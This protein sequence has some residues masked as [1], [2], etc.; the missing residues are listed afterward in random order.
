MSGK[1]KAESGILLDSDQG[2]PC[3]EELSSVA[4]KL[5]LEEL[6]WEDANNDPV[7][8]TMSA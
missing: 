6:Y 2:L 7:A 1:R 8:K 3:K 5:G 4:A